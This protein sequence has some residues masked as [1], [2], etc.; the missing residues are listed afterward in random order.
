MVQAIIFGG[1]RL[2]DFAA[3]SMSS[4]TWWRASSE[5]ARMA[6]DEAPALA[7]E[8]AMARPMP[9]DAP[10]MRTFLPERLAFVGLIAGYVLL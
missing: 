6:M 1:G 3:E 8:I 10:V 4:A 5:R 9:F 7:Y 2:L